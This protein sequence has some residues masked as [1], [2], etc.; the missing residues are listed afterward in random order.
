MTEK[1]RIRGKKARSAGRRFEL[2]VRNDLESDGWIVDKWSNNVEFDWR[3]KDGVKR[4]ITEGKLLQGTG[5]LVK[6]KNK[7]R[8]P[9]IPMML[10]AGFPDFIAYKFVKKEKEIISSKGICTD[11]SIKETESISKIKL[12][13]EIMGV[14]VKSGKYL[15]SIEKEKCRW[16]LD[17][18]IFSKI[19]IASKGEKRG[20]IKYVEFKNEYL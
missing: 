1:N 12:L 10:G 14:E 20:Q 19:L 8:G 7:F 11:F 16:L 3:F 13:Y 4:G 15:D 5:R 6:V 9:G 17:N 2:K 18:N